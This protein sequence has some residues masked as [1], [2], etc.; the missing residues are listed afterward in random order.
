LLV[1]QARLRGKGCSA[2]TGDIMADFTIDP[3]FRDLLPPLSDDEHQRLTADINKNGCR[4]KLV[5]WKEWNILIDGHNRYD[6]CTTLD[7]PY[8]TVEMSFHGRDDVKLWM[9]RNQLARRNITDAKR[10][11]L[12]L[13]LKPVLAAKAK[14]NQSAAGGNKALPQNSAEALVVE[15]LDTREEIAKA[16]GVSHDTVHKVESVMA[17]ADEPTK[18][19]MLAGDISIN[20]AYET[21]R[22][23]KPPVETLPLLTDKQEQGWGSLSE[24]VFRRVRD[25]ARRCPAAK[26]KITTDL[27][28]LIRSL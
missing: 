21:V 4:D 2:F 8:E 24:E 15:S 26:A 7:L 6:I 11:V 22:P 19:K 9:I 16:S 28:K 18:S 5:V 27:R 23:A 25:Y 13:L 12:N 20:K 17:K 3:E 10:V 1:L 14:E